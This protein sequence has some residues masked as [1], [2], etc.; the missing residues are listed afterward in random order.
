METALAAESRKFNSSSESEDYTRA[1]IPPRTRKQSRKTRT[2]HNSISG[3]S[4]PGSIRQRTSSDAAVV[5]SRLRST[6]AGS[7]KLH[8]LQHLAS[9]TLEVRP[10]SPVIPSPLTPALTT[11]GVGTT[12]DEDLSDFQSAYSVSPRDSYSESFDHSTPVKMQDNNDVEEAS[13][14][15]ATDSRFPASARR[16]DFIT[17]PRN[18]TASN[19]TTV[20]SRPSTNPSEDTLGESRP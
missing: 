8:A 14:P 20:N 16:G 13:T 1:R 11:G 7:Q 3:L 6:S 17:V 9:Q 2:N 12:D 19:A 10:Q 4:E 18:R 5:E 15:T